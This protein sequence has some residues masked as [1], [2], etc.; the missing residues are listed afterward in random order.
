MLYLPV[1]VL[2][3][4]QVTVVSAAECLASIS[5]EL[6]VEDVWGLVGR[7]VVSDAMTV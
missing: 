6:S 5:L 4:S 7:E 2:V 3:A 1:G